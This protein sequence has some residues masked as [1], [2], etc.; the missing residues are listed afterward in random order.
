ML[1]SKLGGC[2]VVDDGSGVWVKPSRMSQPQLKA[3]LAHA[4]I[5]W[6]ETAKR[7]ALAKLVKVRRFCACWLATIGHQAQLAVIGVPQRAWWCWLQR[8]VPS[9]TIVCVCV[10]V[11]AC[12]A[13]T[14]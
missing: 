5:T 14:P 2:A 8:L 6:P 13:G 11:C 9:P 12:V 3:E 7:M 4:G 10:C 1:L